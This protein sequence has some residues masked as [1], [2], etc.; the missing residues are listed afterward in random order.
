MDGPILLIA[1]PP[2]APSDDLKKSTFPARRGVGRIA[3]EH[4]ANR[5]RAVR[6]QGHSPLKLLAPETAS[7][8]A[9]I[10][11]STFGGGLVAGDD[12]RL[13]LTAGP[14]STTFLGTQSATK[15]YRSAG[16]QVCRQ[17]L[18]ATIAE[19]ATLVVW[20]DPLIPFAGSDYQQEQSFDLHPAGSLI[21]IDCQVAGRLARNERW[22]MH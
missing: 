6:L 22:A 10:Y 1:P 8:A 4:S 3:I 7:N 18:R 17:S 5:S 13:D 11:V 21:L 14:R 19:D 20:P 15:V 2:S 16:G 9:M 12:I